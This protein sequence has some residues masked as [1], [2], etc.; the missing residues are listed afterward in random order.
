MEMVR[1]LVLGASGRL[2]GMLRV[3][4][5]V[6]PAVLWQSRRAGMPGALRFDPLDRAALLQAARGMDTILCLAGVTPAQAARGADL[7]GNSELAIAALRAGADTGARVLLASSAAVYGHGGDDDGHGSGQALDED[8]LLTPQTAYGR[9]K[10]EMEGR[11]RDLAARLGV[12]L[13]LLRI[14]NVAGADV[15]LGGW[16]PGFVLDRLADGTTPRRSYIGPA[17]FAGVMAGLCGLDAERRRRPDLPQVLNIAAPGAPEMG[18]LLVAAGLPF[19]RR[20]APAEVIPRV[21]L[22]TERL[23]RLMSLA[24]DAGH[25]ATL[26]REW[27]GWRR[28]AA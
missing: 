28:A 19:A 26:V 6:R 21:E 3:F 11:T 9:A 8:M 4:W 12:P 10:A 14:G 5:G 16:R 1:T 25:P 18:A 27:R 2:G 23:E 13:C 20:P 17:T 15:I 7:A 22:A 24:L